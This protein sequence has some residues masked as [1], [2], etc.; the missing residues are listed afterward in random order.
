MHQY[1]VHIYSCKSGVLKWSL[2]LLHINV[3]MYIESIYSS[4]EVQRWRPMNQRNRLQALAAGSLPSGDFEKSW[5]QVQWIINEQWTNAM[6]TE[7]ERLR[8]IWRHHM[9]MAMIAARSFSYL[10]MSSSV[11]SD[12][13][14]SCYWE[15]EVKVRVRLKKSRSIAKINPGVFNG[16]R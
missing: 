7:T 14:H 3:T 15:F 9:S 16:G 4:H 5:E 8:A 11:V 13:N 1:P 6:I 2:N 12:Y 10:Y